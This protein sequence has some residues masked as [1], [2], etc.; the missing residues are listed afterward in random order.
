MDGDFRNAVAST[1]QR[2]RLE[3]QGGKND[4]VPRKVQKAVKTGTVEVRI[5]EA[6][7]GRSQS[8]SRKKA[9]R[10]QEEKAKGEENGRNKKSGRRVE[11]L[12]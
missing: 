2:N 5:A 1:L 4:E 7:G 11:N 6:E 10:K 3:D 12:G 9:R 8:R